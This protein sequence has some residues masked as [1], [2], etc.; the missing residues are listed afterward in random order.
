M[1]W[2]DAYHPDDPH[3]PPAQ[4]PQKATFKVWV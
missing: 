3:T 2:R 4:S 1:K